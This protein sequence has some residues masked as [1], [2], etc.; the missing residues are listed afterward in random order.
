MKIRLVRFNLYLLLFFIVLDLGCN[1]PLEHHKKD[2]EASTL[3]LFVA[4]KAQ[5]G[6]TPIYRQSP[7]MLS[8]DREPFLTEAD[9]DSASLIDLP[10]GFAIRT[11]FNG[12]AAM[13]LQE[14]TVSRKGKYI[15]I[16]SFFGE[17]RWLAAPLIDHNISNGELVFTPDASREE[18]ERIVR[19][20]S[21]VVV[22]IKKNESSVF[23]Q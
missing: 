3:H 14:V 12:H 2:K 13:L 8:V 5:S 9:L 7:I 4:S 22:D 23:K 1:T 11:Q 15:A 20:L 21:N 17:D 19:G 6:G 16:Q 10:G 18:S